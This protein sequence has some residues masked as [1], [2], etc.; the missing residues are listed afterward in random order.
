MSF[1]S[2]TLRNLDSLRVEGIRNVNTLTSIILKDNM[3]F[4]LVLHLTKGFGASQG[5]LTFRPRL[6]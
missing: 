2:F 1:R 3:I 6:H 5:V 4:Q